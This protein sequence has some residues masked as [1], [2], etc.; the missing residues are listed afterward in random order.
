MLLLPLQYVGLVEERSHE[1]RATKTSEDAPNAK[2]S[3]YG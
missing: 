3:S 1:A 2:A